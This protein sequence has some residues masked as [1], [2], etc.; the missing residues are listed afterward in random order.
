MS[1]T[2]IFYLCVEFIAISFLACADSMVSETSRKLIQSG[3]KKFSFYNIKAYHLCFVLSFLVLFLVLGLRDH[4]GMDYES[5]IGIYSNI[6]IFGIEARD[7]NEIGFAIVCKLSDMLMPGAYELM[8]AVIA[9]LT[10]YF[11]YKA[12]YKMSCCW[13]LS[14]AYFIFFGYFISSMNLIRQIL[15]MTI[16]T[17]ACSFLFDNENKKTFLFYVIIAGLFHKSAYIMIPFY[18]FYNTRI[19]RRNLMIYTFLLFSLNTTFMRDVIQYVVSLTRY[20]VY[21]DSMAGQIEPINNSNVYVRLCMLA[22]CLIFAKR[23]I[24]R[25][26]NTLI[27]YNSALVCLII[28]IIAAITTVPIFLRLASY[29]FMPNMFLIPEVLKTMKS[30]SSTIYSKKF[31]VLL[32]VLIFVAY[33]LIGY[34]WK[35]TDQYSEGNYRMIF[36][37]MFFS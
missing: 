2:L 24:S 31:W 32:T 13:Y 20:G 37:S 28:T 15:A 19:T 33:N 10:M 23:T 34:Y 21:M 26:H 35:N 1:P 29:F 6:S 25:N 27:Y 4:I 5:Y 36:F 30:E 3:R 7:R 14:L 9:F 18:F 12:I 22:G 16:T 11:T 8:F 17:Y